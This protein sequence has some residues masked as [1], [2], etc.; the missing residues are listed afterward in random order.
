M[1]ECD[2]LCTLALTNVLGYCDST[3]I[4]REGQRILKQ[5]WQ[6]KECGKIVWQ[7]IPDISEKSLEVKDE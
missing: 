6:C 1:T 3:L 5:A 2:G 7:E 4:G